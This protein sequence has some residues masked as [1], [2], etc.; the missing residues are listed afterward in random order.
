MGNEAIARG[1]IEAGVHVAVGYPGTPSTEVIEN[2]TRQATETG[3]HVEWAVNEKVAID[4]GAGVSYG[5]ARSLVTMKSAGLN[6][7]SDSLISIAYGDLVG[8]LVIYVA[9]DPGLHAG[10]EEEDSR[11]FAALSLLP[12]LDIGD[13]QDSKNAII[14]AFEY[15]EKYSVPVI[16]RSTTRVAHG[17]T[18]VQ[19][20]PIQVV[21]RK[22]HLKR[23]ISTFTRAS[24]VW[25]KQQHTRLIEKVEKLAPLVEEDFNHLTIKSGKKLGVV[26]SG[27]SW[28]YFLDV[29]LRHN[30]DV[31]ALKIGSVNPL[32]VNKLARL[33]DKVDKLLILEELEPYLELRIKAMIA[34]TNRKVKVLGKQD[35]TLPRVGEY[36]FTFVEQ[37]VLK[38]IGTENPNNAELVNM[39]EEAKNLAPRRSLPFCPG[40][41]HRGTYSALKQA[42]KELSYDQDDVI[43]TGD[44]GCTI[45]G[46]HPPFNSCWTE[47]SMG[48]S[49]GLAIGL[50]HA[51]VK[52]TVIATIGDST[53]FHAGMPPVVNA[54][55]NNTPIV[56][57]VLDNKITGMTGHQPSPA[58]GYNVFKQKVSVIEIEKIL[59]ASGIKKISV[60]NPFNLRESIDAFK[61]VIQ[62]K[63]PSAIVL[64][65]ACALVAKRQQL[66]GPPNWIDSEKRTGCLLCV[67]TLSCPAMQIV[68]RK[69]VISQD[70]CDGCGLCEQICPFKAVYGGA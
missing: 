20:G 32:P 6:V 40:C 64:R 59:E 37:A 50:K 41:P 11:M 48:A 65:G 39:Q 8:G 38:L 51:G 53:F 29:S 5:G 26:A 10:M 49:I 25:C 17:K 67:K 61:E 21:P 42:I 44:I 63:G 24:P 18:P 1:A 69:M 33:I 43:V 54:A 30:I 3:M 7:A 34:D 27:V 4:I 13:S 23:D 62:H 28:N 55:W 66:T 9:D 12:M 60:V 70:S 56:I 45:L 46:M 35:G 31:S 68:E 22:P 57:A 14:K 52:T 19:T 16:V 58:S 47:V 2:L 15:S 36:N